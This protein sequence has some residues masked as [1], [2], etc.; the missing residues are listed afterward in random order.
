MV[1]LTDRLDFV[2]GDEG[3]RAARASTSASARSTT[4]LRHYPRKYSTGTTVLGED[5]EPPEEGEHITFVDT[6]TKA[7]VRW[8]NRKPQARISWSSPSATADPR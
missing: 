7:E 4:C 3:G 2:I 6:I 5:S 8:T 1:A